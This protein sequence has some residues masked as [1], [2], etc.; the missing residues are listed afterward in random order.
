MYFKAFVL[1]Y[2][3][4]KSKQEEVGLAFTLTAWS[5]LSEPFLLMSQQV[6]ANWWVKPF[7]W[8]KKCGVFLW[9][10]SFASHCRNKIRSNK[11]KPLCQ[12]EGGHFPPILNEL[13]EVKI[14]TK[15]TKIVPFWTFQAGLF[16]CLDK[17]TSTHPLDWGLEASDGLFLLFMNFIFR[18]NI[19]KGLNF[20]SR[21]THMTPLWA[22]PLLLLSL[23]VTF[24]RASNWPTCPYA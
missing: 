3:L 2:H 6:A 1:F 15:L 14:F 4:S 17:R 16:T 12:L 7:N 5:L 19:Q 21:S 22:P 8:G 10:K 23:Y 18:C 24:L 20:T 13:Y 9:Y 11:N